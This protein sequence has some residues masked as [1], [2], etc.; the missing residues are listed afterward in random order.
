MGNKSPWRV[1]FSFKQELSLGPLW[2]L[3]NQQ[4]QGPWMLIQSP[5][6]NGTALGHLRSCFSQV[7]LTGSQVPNPESGTQ[8]DEACTDFY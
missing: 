7:S 2:T 3:P 5:L 4:G 8:T 1:P 6:P